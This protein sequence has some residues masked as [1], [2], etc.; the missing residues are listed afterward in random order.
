MGGMAEY[1]LSMLERV[2][3]PQKYKLHIIYT[4]V[5]YCIVAWKEIVAS[6][7]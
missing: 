5:Y 2:F 7:N 3:L 4:Y 6:N 1:F